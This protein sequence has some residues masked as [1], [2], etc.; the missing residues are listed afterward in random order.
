MAPNFPPNYVEFFVQ[1]L[2]ETIEIF[3][4]N[5]FAQ[6]LIDMGKEPFVAPVVDEV[7]TTR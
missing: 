1:A 2:H 6:M 7:T 4:R 5:R 3:G